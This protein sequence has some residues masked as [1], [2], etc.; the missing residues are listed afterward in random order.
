MHFATKA[1]K[2]HKLNSN[3]KLEIRKQKACLPRFECWAAA[4]AERWAVQTRKE[5]GQKFPRQISLKIKQIL[6]KMVY[7]ICNTSLDVLISDRN[8]AVSI[9]RAEWNAT[10]KNK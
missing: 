2:E 1:R 4:P 7:F 9:P 5:H 8:S 6:S 10:L 3:L